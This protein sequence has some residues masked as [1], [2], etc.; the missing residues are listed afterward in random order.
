M[1]ADEGSKRARKIKQIAQIK[2]MLNKAQ[3]H[4]TIRRMGCVRMGKSE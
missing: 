1:I 4:K 3:V 2:V